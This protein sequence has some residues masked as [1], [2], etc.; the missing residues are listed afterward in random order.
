MARRKCSLRHE[1]IVFSLANAGQICYRECRDGYHRKEGQQMPA[2]KRPPR[3]DHE[4]ERKRR[5]PSWHFMSGSP[6]E[7]PCPIEGQRRGHLEEKQANRHKEDGGRKGSA[8]G[9][10][11]TQ[12]GTSRSIPPAKDFEKF[13]NIQREFWQN[14]KACFLFETEATRVHINQCIIVREDFIIRTLQRS[15]VEE[16][17]NTL[18]SIG[19][20]KQLQKVCLTLVDEN[21]RLL[22]EPPTSWDAIK[23][24]RFMI[25]NGQ[26]SITASKELQEGGCSEP[27]RSE[28]QMW[29]AYIVWTLDDAKLRNISSFYNCT[30]HL[31]HAKPTWGNQMIN[32]RKIWKICNRPTEKENEGVVRGNGANFNVAMHKV[33]CSIEPG[34]VASTK[35]DSLSCFKILFLSVPCGTSRTV[36]CRLCE[37]LILMP[38]ALY[39]SQKFIAAFVQQFQNINPD[40]NGAHIKG[41]RDLENEIQIITLPT[42]LWTSWKTFLNK[43]IEGEL[44]DLDTDKMLKEDMKFK[45]KQQTL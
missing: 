44:I 34:I 21:N 12:T 31:N 7:N 19:D 39:F 41:P 1:E 37:A 2:P 8:S 23:A 45:L 27:R 6:K 20:V 29:D 38:G 26:H 33:R 5:I 10:T 28:L 3:R 11:T 16:M 42:E 9:V 18:V 40:S 15:L 32:C 35:P 30:N 25:I 22:K 4:Q 17:K 24:R 43:H 13:A 36:I 14:H